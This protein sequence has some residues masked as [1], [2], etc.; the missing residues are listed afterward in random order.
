MIERALGETRYFVVKAL[1]I[2]FLCH[3]GCFSLFTFTFQPRFVSK[4]PSFVFLGS[5]LRKHD[6]L[7]SSD[8]STIYEI[9][10]LPT[11]SLNVDLSQSAENILFYSSSQKPSFIQSRKNDAKKTLKPPIDNP[12][13]EAQRN[14]RHQKESELD[15]PVPPHLPLKLQQK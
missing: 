15:I 7:N 13:F 2:S 3:V 1:F 11:T 12:V 10:T 6:L 5:I 9:D 4:K 8:E 14:D